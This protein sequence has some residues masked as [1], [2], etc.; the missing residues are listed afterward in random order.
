MFSLFFFRGFVPPHSTLVS[1]AVGVVVQFYSSFF[2]FLRSTGWRIVTCA[3]RGMPKPWMKTDGTEVKSLLVQRQLPS[4][5]HRRATRSVRRRERKRALGKTLIEWNI[6]ASG[7]QQ[8]TF[9]VCRAANVEIL[10]RSIVRRGVG[11]YTFILR[12]VPLDVRLS[13]ERRKDMRRVK[14]IK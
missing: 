7:K 6:K 10:T 9:S 12:C 2:L 8:N 14:I 11:W 4:S 1:D 13:G 3:V 5:K